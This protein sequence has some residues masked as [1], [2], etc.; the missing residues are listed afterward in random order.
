M[1]RMPV[2]NSFKGSKSMLGTIIK[3]LGASVA[4]AHAQNIISAQKSK[5]ISADHFFNSMKSNQNFPQRNGNPEISFDVARIY[6]YS[7]SKTL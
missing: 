1:T 7:L 3:E 6:L 5:G 4:P 2:A